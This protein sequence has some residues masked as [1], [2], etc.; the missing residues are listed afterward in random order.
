MAE[1]SNGAAATTDTLYLFGG[2]LGGTDTL[3][4]GDTMDWSGGGMAGI[5]TTR[6]AVGAT[7]TITTGNT[8]TLDTRTWV[9][10]G[11]V[12]WIGTGTINVANGGQILNTG[13]FDFQ[14]DA[15]LD[16]NVGALGLFTNSGTV[17]RTVSAGTFT[18]DIPF[19]NDNVVTVVTGTLALTRGGTHTCGSATS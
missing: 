12:N 13:T 3:V 14:A 11:V 7:T 2:T 6:M 18:I 10:E 5:G 19:N 8:K 1:F 4:V 15:F 9:N 17:T 16:Q